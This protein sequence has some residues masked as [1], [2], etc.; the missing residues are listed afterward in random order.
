[1]KC[2]SVFECVARRRV[3]SGVLLLLLSSI[4]VHAQTYIFGRADFPVGAGAIS[5]ATGDFNGDG[6]LDLAVVNEADNTVSV[7][8]GKPDGTF[9]PQVTYAT[10]LGPLAVVA[11]DF[12][13]DGNLDLAVT[14]GNCVPG[15]LGL[16]TC[17]VRT[18]SMLLGN[19]D[20]SFQP[21][22]DFVTGTQPSSIAAGDFNGDG[23][24]DLAIANTQDGTVSVLLG[25]GDGTFQPEVAYPTVNNPQSVIVA[26]FNG[27]HKLDLAVGGNG[28][29]VLLGNGDGSFQKQLPASG[30]SPL[31]AADFNGD[32]KLDLFAGGS[33]LLG[34][35]NGTFV[36]YATYS[37]GVFAAAADLNGDGK[38]DLV[39]AQGGFGGSESN[40][41][42]L[43][44][45]VLLGNGD[46]TFQPATP[47]GTGAYPD[48]LA[49][50]DFNGDGKFDLAVADP[51]CDVYY[52][53][54]GCSRPEQFPFCSVWVTV[55][56]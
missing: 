49:I 51:D 6:T 48:S 29:S 44:V 36:L 52:F 26:D 11:G 19:G 13:G 34:N 2:S 47:Y 30:G 33:V 53:Y 24:L 4:A 18:V 7:L 17:D 12:N 16:L 20:G 31:A 37:S 5:I 38:P 21:H 35:G 3:R 14:N 22:F 39:I 43:S 10:G 9:E 45:S 8:L 32:G 1:M 40:I 50:A 46:G 42:A 28:V 15:K 27:D 55:R 25:K 41:S 23:K 54:S 56:S